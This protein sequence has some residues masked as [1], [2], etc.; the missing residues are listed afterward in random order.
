M[1]LIQFEPLFLRNFTTRL[2]PFPLHNHNHYE[3]ILIQTGNGI[4]V[5]NGEKTAYE[6]GSVFFLSPEDSHDFIIDE[7]THFSVI[8]FLPG[9]LKGGIN[10][11]NTDLWNNLLL[12]LGRKFSSHSQKAASENIKSIINV[13]ITE[14]KEHHEKVSEIHTHLLRSLLL[15]I[16]KELREAIDIPISDYEI[17]TI[18]RI[19]NYIHAHICFPEKLSIQHMSNTF[20]MSGSGFRMFFTKQMEMPLRDYINS[21]KLQQI[22]ERMNNSTGTL[23]QI[24]QDLGF[25]DSSHLN[26]FFKKQ[27]QM[28]PLAYK[29]SQK[30][31]K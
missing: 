22:K 13:M 23:S 26:R 8:K 3:L 14:W 12:N 1:R 20:G 17:T 9:V 28:N 25:T 30:T 4:H 18:E 2:W 16:D 5:L 10:V 31:S 24:A 21:L 15:I 6:K 27:T 11:S 7:E 19:Q 29:K